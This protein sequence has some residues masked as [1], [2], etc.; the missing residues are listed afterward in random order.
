MW[1]KFRSLC[2]WVLCLLNCPPHV[3]VSLHTKHSYGF[4]FKCLKYLCSCK[5]V[6][7]VYESLH[8]L[9]LKS[10]GAFPFPHTQSLCFSKSF[11]LVTVLL[12]PSQVIFP[13]D[14][15]VVFS[16]LF[17]LSVNGVF[18]NSSCLTGSSCCVCCC[19]G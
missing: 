11:F 7:L 2:C 17:S 6:I 4:F 18:G 13:S 3:N 14:V 8:T 5:F 10:F 19:V 1:G 15:L 9:H 16:S 12:H